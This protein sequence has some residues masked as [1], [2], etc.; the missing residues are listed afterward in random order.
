MHLT[1]NP[2]FAFHDDVFPAFVKNIVHQARFP[3]PNFYYKTIIPNNWF[4]SLKKFKHISTLE[5]ELND[6]DQGSRFWPQ[7]NSEREKKK[8][9]SGT[10]SKQN[11]FSKS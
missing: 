11:F 4:S 5:M 1:S 3:Y 6:I 10:L 9:K 2:Y 7:M 8:F